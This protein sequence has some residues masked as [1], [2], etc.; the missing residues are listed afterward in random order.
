MELLEDLMFVIIEFAACLIVLLLEDGL[1]LLQEKVLGY[2]E[3]TLLGTD[4]LLVVEFVV[5]RHGILVLEPL[6]R[7]ALVEFSG[8]I[9]DDLLELFELG[10]DLGLD[11][12]VVVLSLVGIELLG[13]V[14]DRSPEVVLLLLELVGNDLSGVGGCFL[15]LFLIKSGLHFDTLTDVFDTITKSSGGHSERALSC[16]PL[17]FNFL[18][19]LLLQGF[20]LFIDCVD[21][22]IECSDHL[23]NDQF[24]LFGESLEDLKVNGSLVYMETWWTVVIGVLLLADFRKR[25][26]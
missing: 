14:R 24:K 1:Q 12:V 25:F 23:D 5:V 21:E 17:E 10:K 26:L 2:I 11:F 6:F 9:E 16:N 18:L 13:E 3:E 7:L 20:H 15:D 22:S 8:G 4:D 19:L